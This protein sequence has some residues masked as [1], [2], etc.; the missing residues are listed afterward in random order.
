MCAASRSRGLGALRPRPASA[1]TVGSRF[2]VRRA[3]ARDLQPGWAV[4]APGVP[5]DPGD[6]PSAKALGPSAVPCLRLTA[7]MCSGSGA[8]CLLSL[9][10]CWSVLISL[11]C[12]AEMTLLSSQT[13]SLEPS[14]A[15]TE[16]AEQRMLEK[17]AKVIEELLQTERDYI[18]DLEMCVERVMVPL[19]QAQVGAGKRGQDL[20]QHWW[21]GLRILSPFSS[22]RRPSSTGTCRGNLSYSEGRRVVPTA[23][24]TCCSKSICSEILLNPHPC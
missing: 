2:V 23:P 20:V 12:L 18:R 9:H 8:V 4:G 10:P 15:A 1:R 3:G 24:C 21:T 14:S 22:Q 16:S 19:Q 17:R 11:I 7:Y 6:G 5:A 13:P